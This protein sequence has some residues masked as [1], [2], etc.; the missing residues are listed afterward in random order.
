MH[1]QRLILAFAI[2]VGV[3]YA[4]LNGAFTAFGSAETSPPAESVARSGLQKATF[5][6]G[7]FWCTEADFDKIAGVVSTTSGY[8]GGRVANPTYAQVAFGG[9][10]HAEAVEV[11]FD[12][13]VISYEELVEHYWR[14]VDPFAVDRHFCDVG[15]QYRPEIFVHDAQ[16]RAAA[17]AAKARVEAQFSKPI[18]VRISD[19]GDF[20]RAEA[21]H[22]DYHE[23]NPIQ[24]RYYRWRCGRD[25]RLQELWS[26]H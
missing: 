20:Y 8:A 5:A 1:P 12:P 21:H 24:Y 17:E 13:A 22:Q 26:A 7:C 6:G 2:V 19:A 3:G 14:N 16:Q 10:G 11:L 15:S 25:D 23:K 4:W 9:T 18:A